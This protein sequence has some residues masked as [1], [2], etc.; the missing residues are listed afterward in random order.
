MKVAASSVFLSGLN[1]TEQWGILKT[2]FAPIAGAN[3]AL[4]AMAGADVNISV[5]G[6]KARVAIA[7]V[8]LTALL[9]LLLGAAVSFWL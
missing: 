5:V 1:P 6:T 3:P 2:A 9:S 7:Q 4:P 8:G